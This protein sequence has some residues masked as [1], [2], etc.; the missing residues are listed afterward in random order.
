MLFLNIEMQSSLSMFSLLKGETDVASIN[1][2]ISVKLP[3]SS[4]NDRILESEPR[5]S[6]RR[7]VETNFGLDFIT[8]S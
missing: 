8:T 5:R 1:P 6:K 2:Y 7:R 4:C 3:D